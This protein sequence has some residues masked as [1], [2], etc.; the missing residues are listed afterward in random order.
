MARTYTSPIFYLRIK[1]AV[2]EFAWS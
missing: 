1:S 2:S